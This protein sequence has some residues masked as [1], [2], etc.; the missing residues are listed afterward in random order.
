VLLVAG[1]KVLSLEGNKDVTDISMPTVATLMQQLTALDLMHT[2]VAAD[3][4]G[5][6]QRGLTDLQ[7]IDVCFH[8][9]ADLKT[10]KKAWPAV[11]IYCEHHHR[12]PNW[13]RAGNVAH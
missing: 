7:S 3:G 12:C 13:G 5:W 4:L 2:G 10:V 8:S 1:L 6:L 9:N 11:V